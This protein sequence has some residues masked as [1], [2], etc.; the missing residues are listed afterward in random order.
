MRVHIEQFRMTLQQAD[1]IE[2]AI[3]SLDCVENVRVYERTG[4][5]IIAYRRGNR[6]AVVQALSELNY[7]D[8]KFHALVPE[9]SGREMR[10]KYE[11]KLNNNS[12]VHLLFLL[13]L[14]NKYIHHHM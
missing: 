3:R 9:H 8:E 14:L 4:N 7:E 10:N 13:D 12:H 5:A 11:E 6:H 1:L 2:Y